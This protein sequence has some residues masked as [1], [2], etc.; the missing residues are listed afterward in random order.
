MTRCFNLVDTAF[1]HDVG[2]VAGKPPRL[3]TWDR[4]FADPERP[5]FHTHEAIFQAPTDGRR[6]YGLLFESQAII[7]QIYE[8]APRV[9]DRFALVFTHASALLEARPDRCRFIPGGGIWIGGTQGLGEIAVHPK[10]KLVSIVTSNK[11]WCPLHVFRFELAMALRGRSGVDVFAGGMGKGQPGWVPITETLTEYRYS[12]VVENFRDT[13]YFT[14]KL[15]NCFATGTVPVYCGATGIGQLF[16][17]EG[18][19]AFE[20][21]EELEAVLPTLSP[22]DY[23]R[24]LPAVHDNLARCRAYETI[25]DYMATAYGDLL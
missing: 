19:I 9:L 8:Y 24:R 3:W 14:E 7:P 16:N 10:A 13:L 2:T 23:A 4:S 15:L 11:G 21:R 22:E 17:P 12:I 1:A 25:E 18:I 6:H 20:T 5:T